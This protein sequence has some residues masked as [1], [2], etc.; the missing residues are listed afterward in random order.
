MGIGVGFLTR[1]GTPME[2]ATA[3]LRDQVRFAAVSAKSR[4]APTELLVASSAGGAPALRVRGLEPV[5]TWHCERGERQAA[6]AARGEVRGQHEPGRF[7]DALRFDPATRSAIL[8]VPT[9]GR[10]LWDLADGFLLRVDVKLDERAGATVAQLGRAFTLALAGDAAPELRLV[11]AG[12]G[13]QQ[14]SVKTLA[15]PR[16]LPLRRWVTLEA[17]H[18]GSR[19]TL[20][21]DGAV[22]A[23][24]DAPGSPFQRD[25]DA[26]EVSPPAAPVPG[27]VDEVQLW[28]YT[29]ADAVEM[30]LG[31]SLPGAPA[32]LRFLPAG[33]PLEPYVLSIATEDQT[34]HFVVAPGGVLQ[35]PPRGVVP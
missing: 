12:A 11:L 4:G 19:L 17:V 25:S 3:I 8:R 2:R 10:P 21:V 7:G 20:L 6:A 26:F 23:S 15:G 24:S 35:A 13:G 34:A 31:T 29:L 28:A 9:N 30:P 16:P 32:S 18:D 27:L 22:A 5:G 14:G 33:A 1:R